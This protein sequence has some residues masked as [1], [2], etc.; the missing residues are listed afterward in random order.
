[1]SCICSVETVDGD[2]MFCFDNTFST[3]SEK[4]IFFELILDNTGEEEDQEDWKKYITGTDLLDMKLEDILVCIQSAFTIFVDCMVAVT[5]SPF[6][7]C[8]LVQDYLSSR[9]GYSSST[10]ISSGV[11]EKENRDVYL[12]NI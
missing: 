8:H 11:T 7:S 12:F 9:T 10:T 3:I 6:C 2:Y 1:M 4:V 5:S